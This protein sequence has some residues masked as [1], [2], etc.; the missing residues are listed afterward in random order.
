MHNCSK[1]EKSS[2]I[3]HLYTADANKIAY[4]LCTEC[5][6]L[7]AD[8]K[9]IQKE[10]I[11]LR[12][13]CFFHKWMYYE[14]DNPVLKDHEYDE[15]EKLCCKLEDLHP[16]EMQSSVRKYVGKGCPVEYQNKIRNIIYQHNKIKAEYDR[17]KELINQ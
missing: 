2:N 5:F 4:K 17:L 10:A 13:K 9:Y 3:I 16:F 11:R 1:C 15:L 7:I 12:I 8:K 6:L 14:C